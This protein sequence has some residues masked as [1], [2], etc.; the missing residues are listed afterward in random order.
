MPRRARYRLD[1]HVAMDNTQADVTGRT[2]PTDFLSLA[3]L[4]DVLGDAL[5]ANLPSGSRASLILAQLLLQ[6]LTLLARLVLQDPHNIHG[7]ACPPT[8]CARQDA[9]PPPNDACI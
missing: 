7:Y 4:A 1:V 3:G 9:L 2:C 8:P 6:N 5:F